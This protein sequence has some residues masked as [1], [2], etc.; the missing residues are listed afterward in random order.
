MKMNF[1]D[2]GFVYAEYSDKIFQRALELGC[3]PVLAQSP[4]PIWLCT[5]PQRQHADAVYGAPWISE[6]GLQRS[7]RAAR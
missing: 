2:T 5:C 3:E 6:A 4:S 1:L 7:E